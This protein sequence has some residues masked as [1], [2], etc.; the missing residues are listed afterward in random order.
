MD[1]FD[2]SFCDVLADIFC[3]LLSDNLPQFLLYVSTFATEM[4][5]SQALRCYFIQCSVSPV[6][7]TMPDLHKRSLYESSLMTKT[8][9]QPP[10][11]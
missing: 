2:F 4:Y 9:F 11:T 10:N 8:N 5:T 6:P 1:Y 7:N 3:L